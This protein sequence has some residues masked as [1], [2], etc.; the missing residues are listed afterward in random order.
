M[1]RTLT[2]EII[3]AAI[4]GFEAQKAR[5]DEQIKELREMLSA[6]GGDTA[7]TSAGPA[8][9]KR[10][11]SAAGRARIAEAQRQRWA[12]TKREP[13]AEPGEAAKPKRRLSAAGRKNIVDALRRRWAAKKA[14]AG[15]AAKKAAPR[16]KKAA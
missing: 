4:A 10:R 1:A 11:I 8:P 9:R 2:D 13:A 5:I 3:N 15:R 12:A 14:E 7:S 16:S 6:E